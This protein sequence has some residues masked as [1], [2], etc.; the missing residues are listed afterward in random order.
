MFRGSYNR[1]PAA[2]GWDGKMWDREYM[3]ERELAD[4]QRDG[5]RC[6]K[7]CNDMK[8]IAEPSYLKKQL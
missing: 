2:F 5:M 8:I 7:P 6:K 1:G 4:L 3:F